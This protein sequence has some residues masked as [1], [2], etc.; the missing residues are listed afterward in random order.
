[1]SMQFQSLSSKQLNVT[2]VAVT[3]TIV[4]CFYLDRHGLSG[5]ER[6]AE[7][8]LSQVSVKTSSFALSL[9]AGFHKSF[10][11]VFICLLRAAQR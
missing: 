5:I 4:T 1:M 8:A 6:L 9:G 2:S 7:L 10:V 3:D 11:L